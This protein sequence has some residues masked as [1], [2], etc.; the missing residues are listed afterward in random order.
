MVDARLLADEDLVME[1]GARLNSLEPSPLFR[2]H[3]LF[4]LLVGLS[5]FSKEDIFH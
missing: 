1:P 5:S 3:P 4:S 2:L